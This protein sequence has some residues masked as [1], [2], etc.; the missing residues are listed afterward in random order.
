MYF[1]FRGLKTAP[2][3]KPSGNLTKEEIAEVC[4]RRMDDDETESVPQE[5]MKG[6]GFKRSI[7]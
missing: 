5:R 7:C 3:I 1:Y 2:S 4:K 6:V